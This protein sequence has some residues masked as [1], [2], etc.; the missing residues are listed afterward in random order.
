M[1]ERWTEHQGARS[2]QMSPRKETAA[3][4]VCSTT[5]TEVLS[6]HVPLPFLKHLLAYLTLEAQD[7][8]LVTNLD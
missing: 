4:Q 2:L 8:H 7:V 6:F 1:I 3:K 5:T